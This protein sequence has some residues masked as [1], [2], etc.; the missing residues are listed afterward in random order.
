[1]A[2]LTVRELVTKWGFDIDEKPL[3]NMNTAI[4]RAKKD[5]KFLSIV[6]VAASASI[7]LL[8]KKAGD[9][10]QVEIAFETM[11]GSAETAQQLLKDITTFAAKTPFQLT[12]L[13]ESSKQLLA[14]GVEANNIIPIMTNLGNISA[15]IGKD[16]LPTLIRA[17]GK[18][19][20]KGRATMEELNM[21][22][23][24][25]VPIL[26]QLAKDYG[27]TSNELFKMI[28]QGQ[29]GFENVDKALTGLATGSGKFS[30]LMEKQ[31]K[32]F[33]G[34]MSNIVDTLEQL[35]IGIGKELLP[36]A[37]ELGQEFLKF[38]E[39]N[40]DIIKQNAAEF[41]R[42]VA[43][44]ISVLF[45]IVRKTISVI[46]A[47]I[48]ML[49]GAEKVLKTLA[50]A[51]GIFFGAR[52]LSS[53]G[54]MARAILGLAS[55]FNTMGMSALLA[56]IKMLLIPIA[57]GA[58]ITAIALIA[59]DIYAF[60]Q[61]RDSVFG[62]MIEAFKSFGDIAKTIIVT[63]LTPIR[64]LIN[65]FQAVSDIINTISGNIGLKEL[66]KNLGG[67]VL[68]TLG[69]GAKESLTSALGIGSENTIDRAMQ[70][71]NVNGAGSM[72]PPLSS[73]GPIRNQTLDISNNLNINVVGMPAEQAE[74]VA[75]DSITDV[76][77]RMLRETQRSVE[78]QIER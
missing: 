72:T 48:D 20:T 74:K 44:A 65:A 1:M 30:N 8:L 19:R 2:S 4:D 14:F 68:N 15:G 76:M 62:R 46:A 71:G 32:S 61:G 78:P 23:E 16:K 66:L 77:N 56:Q 33:L 41:F 63:L 21:L 73:A 39:V 58:I 3:Q 12:D 54:L 42:G 37:K 17:F 9:I 13:I 7:G 55:A 28:S 31:S 34:I 22:L 50:I 6:T 26:D 75:K 29:V 67:R 24:A 10:E 53:I 64:L 59:E 45:K 35:A 11:T 43:K 70:A 69:F 47:F 38:F 51:S 49:G 18:I 36:Q 5:L 57:I 52:M 60:S 40:K 25:G 27:V